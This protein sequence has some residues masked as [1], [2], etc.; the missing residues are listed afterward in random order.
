MRLEISW[1]VQDEG[2]MI[3]RNFSK[4]LLD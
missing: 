2:T 4:Y 1:L 3:L